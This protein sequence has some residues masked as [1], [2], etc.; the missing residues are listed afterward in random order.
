MSKRNVLQVAEGNHLPKILASVEIPVGTVMFFLGAA[1]VATQNAKVGHEI[2]SI[3]RGAL[4]YDAR[5]NFLGISQSYFGP[6]FAR[7][8]ESQPLGADVYLAEVSE[9][10]GPGFQKIG[11]IE[12]WNIYDRGVR[13][14]TLNI[15]Q[16]GSGGG[17]G[18]GIDLFARQR[19]EEAY[20]LAESALGQFPARFG[21]ITDDHNFP[22]EIAANSSIT[23]SF[24][25]TGGSVFAVDDEDSSLFYGNSGEG[26]YYVSLSNLL[27]LSGAQLDSLRVSIESPSGSNNPGTLRDG[28]PIGGSIGT[29]MFFDGTPLTSVNVV[30]EN[31]D[32]VSAITLDDSNLGVIGFK[33]ATF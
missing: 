11:S 30:I 16:V 27:R 18:D 14:Y 25:T 9:A 6:V 5:V 17:G 1:Y 32:P 21:R 22:F 8:I 33:M 20:A 12:S 15:D 4:T 3:K 19:A 29:F 23:L 26:L 7:P 2:V 13:G 31:T 10:D 28:I 24:D